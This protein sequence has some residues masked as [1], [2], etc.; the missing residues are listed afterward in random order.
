[1]NYYKFLLLLSSLTFNTQGTF[2]LVMPRIARAFGTSN[3]NARKALLL[4]LVKK[5]GSQKCSCVNMDEVASKTMHLSDAEVEKLVS[6]T[7]EYTVTTA[8]AKTTL[9]GLCLNNYRFD[10]GLKIFEAQKKSFCS[11]LKN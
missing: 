8:H 5:T 9:S 4:D 1:M 7:V 10:K 6:A 2:N 3:I 11:M